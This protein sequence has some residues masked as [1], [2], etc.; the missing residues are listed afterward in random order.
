[1]GWQYNQRISEFLEVQLEKAQAIQPPQDAGKADV[2]A[3]E[4]QL[5]KGTRLLAKH[6]Q[7][8]DIRDFYTTA[9]A[10]QGAQQICAVLREIAE[11]W[12]GHEAVSIA[13]TV[14]EDWVE[15]DRHLL[16]RLLNYI[17]NGV[18]DEADEHV[19]QCWGYAKAKH[20]Y[21]LKWVKVVERE[22]IIV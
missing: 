7:L 6:A 22:E 4:K 1:M 16:Q 21:R 18:E 13:E 20:E 10:Q 19:R 14:P 11:L 2:E 12:H 5:A 8:F 3:F 17:L 15:E 9:D